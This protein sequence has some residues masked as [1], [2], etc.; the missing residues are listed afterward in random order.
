MHALSEIHSRLPYTIILVA[1]T[2][3]YLAQTSSYL[4]QTITHLLQPPSFAERVGGREKPTIIYI[5]PL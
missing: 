5:K 3:N 1:Q 2:S 4:A